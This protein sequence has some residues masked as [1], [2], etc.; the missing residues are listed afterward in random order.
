MQV[1]VV[2]VVMGIDEQRLPGFRISHFREITV[3]EL[4]QLRF[5]QFVAF[6]RY[7]NMELCFLDSVVPGSVFL[8]ILDQF[9]GGRFT[10]CS[11]CAEVLH[12]NQSGYTFRDFPFIVTDSMEVRASG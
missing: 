2:G 7:G 4:Q 6:A 11:E 12:L 3:R 10:E 5:R 8:E 1:S 9:I